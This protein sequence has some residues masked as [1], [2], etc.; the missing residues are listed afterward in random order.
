MYLEVSS[1]VR[2]A[3]KLIYVKS[4]FFFVQVRTGEI[5]GFANKSQKVK[6]KIVKS[7]L[8]AIKA[9]NKEHFFFREFDF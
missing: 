1:K 7:I 4:V 2:I 8:D 3:I 6:K 5:E 9:K